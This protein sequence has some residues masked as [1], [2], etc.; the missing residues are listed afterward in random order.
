MGTKRLYVILT[1]ITGRVACAATAMTSGSLEAIPKNVGLANSAIKNA[2]QGGAKKRH[3]A[4][5]NGTRKSRHRRPEIGEITI[6][7][8][9]L[10]HGAS[11]QTRTGK[12]LEPEIADDMHASTAF[13][14]GL[15]VRTERGEPCSLEMNV[16]TAVASTDIWII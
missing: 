3:I 6:A 11:G 2:T 4:G 8:G 13:R 12:F 1:A 9:C 16:P 5:E 14:V 10:K 7:N 15:P